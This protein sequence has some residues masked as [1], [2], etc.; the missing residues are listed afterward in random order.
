MRRQYAQQADES[1]IDMTP[2]LDIVFIL[3]I[4]FIVSTSFIKETG[5]DVSRPHAVTAT[6]Q[7]L[8]TI[9]VAIDDRNQVWIDN[10]QIDLGALQANV[11]RLTVQN[12]EGQVVIQA[13]ENASTGRFVAVMDR[14]RA[15]GIDNIAIAASRPEG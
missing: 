3:L 2:M 15:A 8:A 9:L 11:E 12:P 14:I 6:R 4:F 10:R 7:E 1:A 13:D 5:I